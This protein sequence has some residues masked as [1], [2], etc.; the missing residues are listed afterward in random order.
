MT[1]SSTSRATAL[2][3]IALSAALIAISANLSIPLQPVPFSLLTFG[4]GL[5]ASLLKPK[6]ALAAGLIYLLMGAIGL[7]VFANA[8]AGFHRLLGPTAGFLWGI[9]LYL[10]VTALLIPKKPNRAQ[11]FLANLA[12]DSLL[13]VTGWL[14]LIFLGQMDATTAFMVGI[15]PFI[16]FD[17]LKLLIISQISHRLLNRKA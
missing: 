5:V 13:F 15:L 11:L 2:A 17:L 1:S 8:G 10:L 6:A 12:G 9:P 16:P 3:Q 14:G 4:I 7:P